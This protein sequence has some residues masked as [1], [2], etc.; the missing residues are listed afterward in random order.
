MEDYNSGDIRTYVNNMFSESAISADSRSVSLADAIDSKAEGVFLWAVLITNLILDCHEKGENWNYIT[1]RLS[2]LPSG[3]S[4][5]YAEIL[6]DVQASEDAHET[7][8]F[9]VWSMLSTQRLS[10]RE[11]HHIFPFIQGDQPTSF[12]SIAN[13]T[14]F[15]ESDEQLERKI[16]K[17][18]RGLVEVK[19]PPKPQ[20]LD[21]HEYED[22]LDSRKGGAG[23][24][25]M[26]NGEKRLV[27][28]IHDS[29]AQFFLRGNGF[30]ILLSAYQNL[31]ESRSMVDFERAP[32]QPPSMA[33]AEGHLHIMGTCLS[34]L[35]VAELDELVQARREA[36]ALR[37][38][39]W[40]ESDSRYAVK[41]CI[42]RRPP[43]PPTPPFPLPYAG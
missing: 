34:Y 41:G 38:T 24:L 5:I 23:S 4:D 14:S 15:I 16:R 13:S 26:D 40:R 30:N 11:W 21:E 29:V 20:S 37:R 32:E 28:I 12:T 1:A 6:A 39:D 35:S 25:D 33:L 42:R 9:F 43:H 7:Y 31:L 3:L 19:R 10:L 27:E 22:D 2:E 36:I 18:S 17:V 8:H